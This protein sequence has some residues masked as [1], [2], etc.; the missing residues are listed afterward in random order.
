MD[1][2]AWFEAYIGGR[3]YT[4]DP[5]NNIPRIGRVLIARGRDATDVAMTNVS[6][7]VGHDQVVEELVIS[8]THT[9]PVDWILPGVAPTGKRVNPVVICFDPISLVTRGMV[10]M[11][12]PRST[13]GNES[14]LRICAAAMAISP[15]GN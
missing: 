3:W 9:T 5:R 11:P 2:A 13:T 8:F 1:F 4:F 10:C 15:L 7:T 12:L 14:I 6:R